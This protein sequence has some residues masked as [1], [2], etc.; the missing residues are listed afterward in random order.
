MT[1]FEKKIAA[2][3][4]R[5]ASDQFSNHT[6]N[7]YT[8]ENTEDARAFVTAMNTANGQTGEDAEPN[9]SR[10]GTAIYTGDSTVMDYC[11]DLLEKEATA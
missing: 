1:A 6:C 2:E 11:A 10:D 3:M 9:V 8:L 7:D 4:L 5:L